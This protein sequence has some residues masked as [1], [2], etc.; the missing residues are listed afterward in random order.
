MSSKQ[1]CCRNIL[2]FIFISYKSINID[3]WNK[4]HKRNN[5]LLINFCN[6]K[7]ANSNYLPDR[8]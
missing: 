1:A 7:D 5:V 4:E 2:V 8:D 6:N 3:V